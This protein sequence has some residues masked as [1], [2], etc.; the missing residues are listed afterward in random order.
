MFV[1]PSEKN[2][3]FIVGTSQSV[4]WF[5]KSASDKILY[6]V[7]IYY[8]IHGEL[9]DQTVNINNEYYPINLKH[10]KKL[11]KIFIEFSNETYCV[12]NY[13]V[14]KV[15]NISYV[16][17][18]QLFTHNPNFSCA[19][20]ICGCFDGF[21]QNHNRLIKNALSIGPVMIFV[22]VAEKSELKQRSSSA[23]IYGTQERMDAVKAFS[24]EICKDKFHHSYSIVLPRIDSMK[25][26]IKKA[27][28]YFLQ[29][30]FN[31]INYVCGSDQLEYIYSKIPA[32]IKV[33]GIERVPTGRIFAYN[34]IFPKII[35][36]LHLLNLCK[37]PKS[38]LSWFS[39]SNVRRER[40]L[41]R[42]LDALGIDTGHTPSNKNLLYSFSNKLSLQQ[43]VC[44]GLKLT[45]SVKLC[46]R[47]D[48][49]GFPIKINSNFISMFNESKVIIIL[50]GR[51]H[52]T[53]STSMC[54]EFSLCEKVIENNTIAKMFDVEYTDT[55]TKTDVWLQE[56]YKNDKFFNSDALNIMLDTLGPRFSSELFFSNG[57][58][59]GKKLGLE[60]AKYRLNKLTILSRSLG[61]VMS[62]MISNAANA[63]ME[64]IGYDSDDI[65]TLLECVYSVD[66]GN[67]INPTHPL[68]KFT[69][70]KFI[71]SQDAQAKD[72]MSSY[73]CDK[74]SQSCTVHHVKTLQ[75]P[76]ID[77]KE[78]NVSYD[79]ISE[80][81]STYK[82]HKSIAY[83][84]NSYNEED[85]NT[86]DLI[87]KTVIDS[88]QR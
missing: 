60:T 56:L 67:V 14:I 71:G 45:P 8:S 13:K 65:K 49:Y 55:N 28:E 3:P 29:K 52:T 31:R 5:I 82:F 33:L 54:A 40:S 39:S 63:S 50:P 47:T 44:R 79:D 87:K 23:F 6:D 10:N 46:M 43:F 53:K 41:I 30:G 81:E 88:I 21:T 15:M 38:S 69:H 34:V 78:K 72:K 57:K 20:I 42:S 59:Y 19:S 80:K 9:Y 77:T 22:E 26:S 35:N 12:E 4:Y 37:Y 17:P 74:L 48:Q 70:I 27:N 68:C 25:N 2:I 58:F 1:C 7:R 16:S 75:N 36:E 85:V 11:V 84:G 51:S 64:M 24:A 62:H 73:K 76:Y 83:L 61:G 86:C 32:N 18:T 66:F